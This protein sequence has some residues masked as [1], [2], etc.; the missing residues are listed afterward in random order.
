[1]E[2]STYILSNKELPIDVRV[3]IETI[4]SEISH[5]GFGSTNA[6]VTINMKELHDGNIKGLQ[7]GRK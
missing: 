2:I 5:V 3:K 7:H 1:M 6:T 4:L